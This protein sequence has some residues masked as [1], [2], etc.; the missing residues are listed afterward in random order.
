MAWIEIRRLKAARN[1]KV[2]NSYK[3][4]W[5][6][7]NGRR[8]SK[9]FRTAAD[10]RRFSREIERS[11]DIGVYRDPNLGKVT[12]AEF[13]RHHMDTSP[14]AARSTRDLYEMQWRVHIEPHLGSFRLNAISKADV[15]SFL[16]ALRDDGVGVPTVNGV[17]RLLRAVLSVAVDEDR[18]S[19]N[20]ASRIKLPAPAKRPMRVLDA[21]QVEALAYAVDDRYVTLIYL[22]AYCGPRIGEAAALRVKHFDRSH[23]RVLIEES[24]KEVRGGLVTGPPK[25]KEARFLEL[26]EFL[27]DM[28]TRHIVRY[29]DVSDPE[30][31]VFVTVTGR[32]LRANGFR[33]LVLKPALTEAGLP[34]DLRTHDLRH[35]AAAIAI[36]AGH[37]AKEIQA[38]LG[39]RSSAVTMDVYSHIL[40][41]VRDESAARLHE[42]YLK[43]AKEARE[44]AR[45]IKFPDRPDTF[46]TGT[47]AT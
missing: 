44:E 36:S 33:R 4:N 5:R 16:A 24:V 1:G 37:H 38:L 14:P 9:S 12:L 42:V 34:T 32:Q 2:Q 39:H 19:A 6:D 3:V 27:S 47:S 10:A 26:P 11:K 25:N 21:S 18:I 40:P 43:A 30:A 31:L 29:S 35:S 8:R 41:R 22:L 7:P 45:V 15:K 46:Q 28:L 23:R 17:Y 13:F 20:P